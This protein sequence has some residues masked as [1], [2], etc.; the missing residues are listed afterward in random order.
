MAKE[1]LRRL[2]YHLCFKDI[3]NIGEQ[4]LQRRCH[5]EALGETKENI[6]KL[7]ISSFSTQ[8]KEKT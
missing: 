7:P 8:A 6:Q 3:V 2:F 1:F 4:F 5:A